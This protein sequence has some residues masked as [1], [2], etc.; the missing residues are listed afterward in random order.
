MLGR[1]VAAVNNKNK[2]A[3][4]GGEEAMFDL[5]CGFKFT[6]YFIWGRRRRRVADPQ[7]RVYASRVTTHATIFL[8]RSFFVHF[9]VYTRYPPCC[10]DGPPLVRHR[11]RRRF[12]TGLEPPATHPPFAA[13]A[14]SMYAP[15]ALIVRLKNVHH[16]TIYL[17]AQ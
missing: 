11:S 17:V 12:Q 14:C 1:A 13:P 6:S 16:G 3:K 5:V 7:L 9:N 2:A 4:M 8:R 10:K 15:T